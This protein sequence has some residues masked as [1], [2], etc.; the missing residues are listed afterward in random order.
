MRARASS[1]GGTSK[2]WRHFLE[3]QIAEHQMPRAISVSD[4]HVLRRKGR[5]KEQDALIDFIISMHETCSPEEAFAK[6][7]KWV[8]EHRASPH[9]SALSRLVPGMGSFLTP[10]PLTRALREYDAFSGL[11]RRRYVLPNFA[12]VRHVLNIAQ[13]HALSD[14]RNGCAG[15]RLVT[16]DADGT[17]YEDG[18]H[19]EADNKMISL[20]ISLMERGVDVAIVTAAGYDEAARFEDRL[21]ALLAAF[22]ELQLPEETTKRFHMM[23]GECNYL[24]KVTTDYGLDF[25]PIE[26]WQTRDMLAWREESMQELLDGAQACLERGAARLGMQVQLIRKARAVG[27]V[28]CSPTLYES[29]EELALSVRFELEGAGLEVPFCAFNGGNDVFVD[30]GNKAI[31]LRALQS[32]L[33]VEEGGTLHVGDRFTVTGNDAQVRGFCSILWVANPDE[34]A[35]YVKILVRDMNVVEKARKE[36][37]ELTKKA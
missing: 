22:K 19:F 32:Y 5:L 28:P 27:V 3:A 2:Y 37:K 24:L 33:G 20:L 18:K 14:Q 8:D 29:L 9:G 4:T 31:G 7:E 21:A 23:G 1:A 11:S 17:L 36:D 10:L 34:T 15:C 12:E 30:V 6:V 26:E 16:F 13:V 25:V 35:F